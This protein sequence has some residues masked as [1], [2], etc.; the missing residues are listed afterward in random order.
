MGP[1]CRAIAAAV[2]L[3]AVVASQVRLP[4]Q[5]SG[6]WI[7]DA[8]GT[9]VKLRCVNWAGHLEVNLPEG[10]HARPLAELA[11]WVRDRGFNCVRLTYSTDHALH[12][13]VSIAD[14]FAG[15]A[16]ATDVP[17]SDM[18][19]LHDAAVAA[20]P[21]LGG[22]E[23]TTR[24]VFGTVIDA[25]WA[26][27]VMTVLDNHVSRAGWCCDL[28]DGNGWWDVATGYDAANSRFFH[29]DR[30]LRGLQAMA[31][32]DGRHADW[33]HLLGRAGA[34]VHQVNPDVLVIIGGTFMATDLSFVRLLQPLNTTGWAGKHVWEWHT[35]SFSL[36]VPHVLPCRAR[37][38]LYGLFAGFV[39]RQHQ[40]YTG[41]LLLSEF[42]V[43]QTGGH[44]PN[45][46]SH[47]DSRYLSCLVDYLR[48]NDAEWAVW[49]LQGS[50]YVRNKQTNYNETWDLLNHNWTAL[51]NPRF[52][53]LL[54]GI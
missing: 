5:T 30:W 32:A 39:L 40:P 45:G 54:R 10:L 35:Y 47:L 4:L 53:E 22:A 34:L 26:R 49:A 19:A 29:T 44:G 11:D 50:Y 42:G 51:R 8:S 1:V 37:Q 12:P 21:F 25:L 38:Q 27:G 24:D 36:T 46:L 20:N 48:R 3:A 31:D 16:A 33:Y 9:R 18:M 2:C 7:V 6:R 13:D 52:F 17:I 14:A 43:D 28:T 23:T 15:A 41:P